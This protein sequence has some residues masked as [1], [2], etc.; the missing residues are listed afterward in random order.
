MFMLMAQQQIQSHT[1]TITF[2]G[3]GHINK[4]TG[5]YVEV[6]EDGNIKLDAAGK[7]VPGKLN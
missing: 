3:S 6:D 2:T 4:V 1:Q 7:P 5:E